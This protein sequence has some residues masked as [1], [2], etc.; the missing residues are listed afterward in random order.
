MIKYKYKPYRPSKV[1]RSRRAYVESR[2]QQMDT[3]YRRAVIELAKLGRAATDGMIT[4]SD[5]VA[6][7]EMIKIPISYAV[8]MQ[9][10]S[11][12]IDNPSRAIYKTE[13][14]D[15]TKL[16][17]AEQLNSHDKIAG[18]YTARY[19][20]NQMI[21]EKEGTYWGKQL[22]H[23]EFKTIGGR[24]VT[25]GA[26]H[27]TEVP[28]KVENFYWDASATELRGDG[29]GV[30]NDAGDREFMSID[31]L[32]R[33]YLGNKKYKNIMC[34][35]PVNGNSS[36]FYDH[37]WTTGHEEARR[38]YLSGDEEGD[39]KP[40]DPS[41]EVVI[42]N[43]YC[44]NFYDEATGKIVDVYIVYANEV[45]IR[46]SKIPVPSKA[47]KPELPYYK[48]VAIPSGGMA[49]LS[50]PAIIRHPET[51]LQRMITMAD[52][53]AELA[54]NPVQFMS[55][56][57]VEALD[58]SPLVPG[59]RVEVSISGRSVADEI[60]IH[61][62]PDITNGAQYIINKMLELITMISGVDIS[63]LFESPK[64]KAI[65]TER[66]REIQERLL[67][68]SVIYNESHGFTDMEEMRLRIMLKNYPIKRY[69]LDTMA[70]GTEKV[71]ARYPKIPVYG[72]E[73]AVIDGDEK[74]NVDKKRYSLKRNVSAYSMLTI[75]MASIDPNTNLY[76]VGA[77]EA[78]NDDTFKLNKNLEKMNLLSTNP[79][80]SQT[81]DPEKASHMVFEWLN[82]DEND[83][84]REE[85]EKSNSEIHPAMKEIQALMLKDVMEIPIKLD[86][87]YDADEFVDVF[88]KFMTLKEFSKLTPIV[89][90]A[91][92]ERYDFHIKNSLNPY[93]KETLREQA[94][95]AQ[96][97]DKQAVDAASANKVAPP[98]PN[99]MT[100]QVNSKAGQLGKAGKLPI[101]NSQEQTQ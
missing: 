21:A 90:K 34:V 77:T 42:K 3:K 43:Y 46:K 12:L 28:V 71:I 57:I 52:A 69:F 85:L 68:F 74:A 26:M 61:R 36:L 62:V 55:S 84:I 72:Y 95:Q 40:G 44:R 30:A 9:R 41:K 48:L 8:I 65:S 79:Y 54:V 20:Q 27:S 35:K 1:E 14:N 47:G 18:R 37:I 2:F 32:R 67:R 23:E 24:S 98:N 81:I 6:N 80:T 73:V 19:Q 59:D 88:N 83:W 82:V 100:E 33:L 87:D 51:A 50:I 11:T 4:E 89:T 38:Q 39:V 97:A 76:V 58:A 66:K 49:G 64:T 22:W 31:K 92:Y 93:Y 10:L 7:S 94:Q 13:G 16:K 99:E 53:Q 15:N 86:D 101:N 75:N 29:I 96:M 17:I 56:S 70:D 78:A 25:V 5:R 45:E 91:I 60:Y 63:A